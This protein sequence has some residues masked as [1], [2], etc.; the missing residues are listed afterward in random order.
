MVDLEKHTIYSDETLVTALEKLNKVPA[1]LTLFVLDRHNKL[2]GTLT[3]GDVRRGL[4]KGLPVSSTVLDFMKTTFCSLDNEKF[5]PQQIREIKEKGVKLLP[6]LDREGR[7]KSVIDFSEVNTRLPVDAVIMAGGRGERMLPLT[8]K[9]PKPLLKLGDKPIIDHVIERLC[10]FG[11]T[12]FKISVNYL[13]EKIEKHLGD[14]S[15]RG[16][17]I[18][19]IHEDMPLG[20]IGALGHAGRFANDTILVINADVFTNM[21]VENFYQSFVDAEADLAIASVP[22]NIEVPFAVISSDEERTVSGLEEKPSLSFNASA[23]IYIF[24]KELIKYIPSGIHFDAPD[25]VL[26]VINAGRKVV[27]HPLMGYWIDIGRKEDY[28]KAI[29]YRSHIKD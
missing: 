15:D 26:K 23:G 4:I 10:K 12:N 27:R 29:E 22:Y 13:G 19:Y 25:F 7:I 17:S 9:T 3:D 11:I 8:A 18:S 16:I 24:K 21:D 5:S 28:L 6:V 14:G 2:I 1:N 20:T